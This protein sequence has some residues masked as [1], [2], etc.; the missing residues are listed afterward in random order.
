MPVSVEVDQQIR[1]AAF[2]RVRRLLE[3]RDP[4]TS[5]D[6]AVGFPIS[7]EARPARQSLSGNLQAQGDEV[8]AFDQDGRTRE[9]RKIW[10][11]DQ[12]TAP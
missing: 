11:D 1:T 12:R 7:G 6:L 5:A 8:P 3:I 10:Y 9:G 4:L 2:I